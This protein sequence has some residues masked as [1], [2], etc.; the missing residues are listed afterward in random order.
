M[1]YFSGQVQ[2]ED[3]GGRLQVGWE[4]RCLGAPGAIPNLQDDLGR[5]GKTVTL[6]L[7]GWARATTG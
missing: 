6:S 1:E 7:A 3:V 5:L 2:Q 4:L